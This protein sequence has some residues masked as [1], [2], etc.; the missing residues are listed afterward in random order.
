LALGSTA[1]SSISRAL[2]ARLSVL[3]AQQDIAESADRQDL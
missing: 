1:Y 3:E 2:S